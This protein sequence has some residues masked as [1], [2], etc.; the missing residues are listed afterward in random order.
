[1]PYTRVVAAL[2]FTLLLAGV[3]RG[4]V[5]SKT[6]L[7]GGV[8]DDTDTRTGFVVSAVSYTLH[9]TQPLNLASV[10]FAVTPP[11][12]ASVPT[13]VQAQVVRDGTWF[14]CMQKPG[15]P[16]WICPLAGVSIAD[17]DTLTVLP[18]MQ[19]EQQVYLPLVSR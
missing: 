4:F 8:G 15:S 19:Y 11:E 16:T 9:P 13:G 7:I 1:M 12:R 18:L 10:Q 3:A 2:L 17:A 5:L 14:P 6:V